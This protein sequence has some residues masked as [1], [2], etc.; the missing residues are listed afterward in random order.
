MKDWAFTVNR[1]QAAPMQRAGGQSHAAGP[2]RG[3]REPTAVSSTGIPSRRSPQARDAETS[4]STA[5][6]SERQAGASPSVPP[7][8]GGYAVANTPPRPPATPP[9]DASPPPPAVDIAS[10]LAIT[11]ASMIGPL[12]QQVGWVELRVLP[13]DGDASP[14]SPFRGSRCAVHE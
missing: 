7:L 5:H 2:R 3:R 11:P 10:T 8:Y 13:K 14:A 6:E 9:M 4:A 1:H 12:A